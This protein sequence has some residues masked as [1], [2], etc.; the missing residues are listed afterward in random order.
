M[1]CNVFGLPILRPSHSPSRLIIKPL[2]KTTHKYEQLFQEQSQNKYMK[3]HLFQLLH[4]NIS[5]NMAVAKNIDFLTLVCE[6]DVD[7]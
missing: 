5:V 2:G 6:G 4:V 7:K 1:V 3:V